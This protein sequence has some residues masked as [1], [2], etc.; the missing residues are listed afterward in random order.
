MQQQRMLQIQR[1]LVPFRGF[2][3]RCR[4][5][6][7]GEHALQRGGLIDQSSMQNRAYFGNA[8]LGPRLLLM[9]NCRCCFRATH[10]FSARATNRPSC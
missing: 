2:F 8:S 1:E 4:G 7:G 5:G 6:D 10:A 9:G 3:A